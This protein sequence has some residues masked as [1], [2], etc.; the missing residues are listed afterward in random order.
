MVVART[1]IGIVD[2]GLYQIYQAY[3]SEFKKYLKLSALT[4][5]EHR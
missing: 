1:G 4:D 2:I 3:Y 5:G